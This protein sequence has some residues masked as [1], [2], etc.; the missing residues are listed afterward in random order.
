MGARVESIA[1]NSTANAI[2]AHAAAQRTS[3]LRESSA[4]GEWPAHDGEGR[5]DRED[6]GSDANQGQQ[7]RRRGHKLG[8]QPLPGAVSAARCACW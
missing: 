3:V 1:G 2:P 4:G 7:D 5:R 8:W 6:R